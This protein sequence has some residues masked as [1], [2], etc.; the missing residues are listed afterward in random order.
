MTG[1]NVVKIGG[2]MVYATC[3]IEPTENDGV[4]EKMLAHVEK[5]QRKGVRW[6]VKVGFDAGAGNPALEEEIERNWAGRTKYDPSGGQ[7]GP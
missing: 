7:W 4:I 6:N 3:Y 1:L 5:E 2:T